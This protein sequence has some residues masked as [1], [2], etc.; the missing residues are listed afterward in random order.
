M[1][2]LFVPALLF[3]VFA[4]PSFVFASTWQIDMEHST[5]GFSVRHMMITNVKGVFER[6]S[7]KVVMDESDIAKSS[8]KTVIETASINTRI[9]KR[10]DHLRSSDFFDAAVF[11][12]M[13]FVSKKIAAAGKDRLK[14]TGD[15]T[16]HGIT[17][18]VVLDVENLTEPVKDP[19]G[20]IRRGASATTKINRRDY[21]LA[22]NKAI[23]TGGVLVGDEVT[24]SL[25]I[26][27]LKE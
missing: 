8:V 22:W 26:E 23:E 11:P 1:K 27:M 19:W 14:V 20:K 9:Q 16:I 3:F 12:T 21:G 24:I 13:T 7:G 6:F 4:A 18:E 15:L 5:I 10:D 17:R 2:K 25:E